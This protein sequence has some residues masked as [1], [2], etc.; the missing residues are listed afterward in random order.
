MQ[1]IFRWR[2]AGSLIAL[3]S[4][5]ISHSF[6]SV[7]ADESISS[8]VDKFVAAADVALEN[9]E[10]LEAAIAYRKA[11]ELSDDAE[12]ARTATR[13][14]FTYRFN[15]EALLAAKRWQKLDKESIEVRAYLG[16]LYFRTDD[17]R[18]ARRQFQYLIKEGPEEPGARLLSMVSYLSEENQPD[19]ADELMRVLAKPYKDSAMAHYAVAILALRAGDSEYAKKR[20]ME[21]MALEPDYMRPK[22][23]YAR[24]LM[25]EGETDQAIEYLAHMIG[26]SPHPD[27]D[28]RM[29]LALMY[30]M[31]G[32]DDD[33]LSQVN[34]VLLEQSRRL[35]ALRLMAIIN[36][37]LERLDAA[38]DDFEDL[39]ETGQ[40]RMDALFYLGR[41]SD[42]RQQYK[43]A[44]QY[45]EEVKTGSNALFSQRRAAALLAHQLDDFDAAFELLDAFAAV[46]PNH[47]VEVVELK[48]QLLVSLQRYDEGLAMYDKSIEYRPD[49]E[50]LLLGRSDLLLRAGRQ[51]EA[52]A[53][54]RKILKRWP[55]SAL[56]LNALGYTLADRTDRY[57]EAEELIRDA[58]KHDPDNPAIID[59]LGWVL[60]KL[61][62]HEAA[63]EQLNLAYQQFSDPEVA[64]HIVEV[65][66]ELDRKEE[67]LET[68]L[69]AEQNYPDSDLLKNVR[70]RYFEDTP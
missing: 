35:D 11:A 68:L 39:L 24:A 64:A 56:T 33:A 20:A 7:L 9:S 36:F 19:R 57:D 51:D 62:Q 42:Y 40:F 16:Q 59:S 47:A 65:L 61:G 30:M 55:D 27:P 45:Y 23:L 34:Q 6:T 53:A 1:K 22:L 28:A 18:N 50:S 41:I 44:V 21:S 17:L 29:E 5:T 25:F 52:I 32:R 70:T 8:D 43:R 49:N 13:L 60:Y 46:A 15:D 58:L 69:A 14:S 10:Y 26:D 54:Y 48:A 3:L 67:A 66:A 12:L 38:W 4:L 2:S 37:R 63:L 31:S